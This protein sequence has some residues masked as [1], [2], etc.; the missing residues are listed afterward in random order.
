MGHLRGVE[1]R[2]TVGRFLSTRSVVTKGGVTTTTDWV[3][4]GLTLLRSTA[5][6][7]GQTTLVDYVNDSAGGPQAAWVSVLHAVRGAAA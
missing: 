2:W 3:Y 6:T 4:D 1:R 7:S 5:V